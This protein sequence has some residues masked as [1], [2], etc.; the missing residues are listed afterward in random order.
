MASSSGNLIRARSPLRIALVIVGIIVA[1]LI[2]QSLPIFFPMPFGAQAYDNPD[3]VVYYERG[4]EAGARD[5]FDLVKSSM[6]EL[7]Q[8]M[9]YQPDSKLQIYVYKAQSSVWIR[10]YGLA[11]MLIAPTWYI[12]D[13]VRGVVRIVSPNTA[14]PRQTHDTIL[15]AVLHEIVHS[16]NYHK[17]PRLSYFWDNGLATYISG[18]RPDNVSYMSMPSLDDTHTENE[19]KFGNMGGYEYSYSY[20]EYLDGKYGWDKVIEYAAGGKT[21]EQVFGASEQQ[22]YDGWAN[23][24]KP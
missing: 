7:K 4:D 14:V 16:I 19:I 12:G 2:I 22:I 24:L 8:R 18:Q 21:Y 5:V 20:V 13:T 15:S 6:G 9:D 3:F 11:T 1:L 10:K 17:N 23:S